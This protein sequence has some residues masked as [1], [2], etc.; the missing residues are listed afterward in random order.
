MSRKILSVSGRDKK[1][2]SLNIQKT[3]DC[4]SSCYFFQGRKS[5]GCRTKF[6][7]SLIFSIFSLLHF[8]LHGR[9]SKV[10]SREL[11]FPL[12]DSQLL[13]RM[14]SDKNSVSRLCLVTVRFI[15]EI[16]DYESKWAKGQIR[17]EFPKTKGPW[18]YLFDTTIS[19]LSKSWKGNFS[20]QV[21]QEFGMKKKDGTLTG[22]YRKIRDN[23]SDFSLVLHDFPT[24][25]YDKVDPYQVV[26]ELFLKILSSYQSKTEANVSFNDFL[27]TSMKSFDTGTW[28]AVLTMVSAFFGLW[29][30]K[31]A[32][33]P[34][35]NHVSLR[36]R[37]FETLWDTLLLFISQES[38]DYSKFLDRFLSIVMTISFFFLTTIYF[39]LMST[40]LI[41][42]TKP[43][44]INSYQDIMNRPNITPIFAETNSETQEFEDA[45]FDQDDSI[46]AKFWAKYKDKVE[47]ISPNSNPAKLMNMMHK[48][49]DTK[50]VL[51]V[52][53][54]GAAATRKVL[55]KFKIAC[56]MFPNVYSWVS[57]DPSARMHQKGFIMRNGMKQTPQLKAIRRK[58]RSFIEKGIHYGLMNAFVKDA[59]QCSD[60][61]PIPSGSH[62][63]VERCLSDQVV[64]ADA[65]V[66]TVVLQNFH[67]LLVSSVVMLLAS[68]ITLLIELYCHRHQWVAI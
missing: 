60:L 22:C 7:F 62:S 12:T 14:E 1:V 27:L 66:D 10:N 11:L 45:Y 24:I 28:F 57:R 38:T 61:F 40:D 35:N 46:Q 32:L 20:L 31:R 15:L 55:C 50:K 2:S 23:E 36:K 59:L 13:N 44:V 67:V 30:T 51:I 8:V 17:N 68:I 65:S 21:E 33:F 41:S 63:Q 49:Y 34:D 37:I 6:L 43:A 16:V 4:E 5:V 48:A 25:D 47:M 52:N 54:V 39:G 58:M 9:R 3:S 53:D 56:R 29:M 64:Y 26:A 18:S 19:P 42:V